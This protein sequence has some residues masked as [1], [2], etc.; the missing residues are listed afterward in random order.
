[1]GIGA[2]YPLT[3]EEVKGGVVRNWVAFRAASENESGSGSVPEEHKDEGGWTRVD[4][5]GGRE[6]EGVEVLVGERAREW[7][8]KEGNAEAAVFD[9][10]YVVPTDQLDSSC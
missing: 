6:Y 7:A 10:R 2:N 3:P 4:D 5:M 9:V 1:M 8:S